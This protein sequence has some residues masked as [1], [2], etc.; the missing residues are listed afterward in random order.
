MVCGWE[1][2]TAAHS[3]NLDQELKQMKSMNAFDVPAES[4][5]KSH[6]KWSQVKIHEARKQF[7]Q[8]ASL[9]SKSLAKAP[10]KE[11]LALTSLSCALQDTKTTKPSQ[12]KAM[13]KNFSSL[14]MSL[15]PWKN[16]WGEV[17]SQ[18]HLQLLEG[19]IQEKSHWLKS[20]AS[21]WELL[22]KENLA[23]WYEEAGHIALQK[24][25]LEEAAYY[26]KQ[27]ND[28]V[29]QRVLQER[30]QN[31]VKK[32]A[33][34]RVAN[35]IVTALSVQEVAKEEE[36][37]KAL[38]ESKILRAQG[39]MVEYLNEFPQGRS[40]KKH[41]DGALDIYF[42]QSGSA[43][44]E[45][46]RQLAKADHSRIV[47]W[48]STL[49]RKSDYKG[50]LFLA[51]KIQGSLDASPQ[52]TTPLWIGGRSAHF[53]G[54]YE[55]AE[56][57]YQELIHKHLGTDQGIEALF[58]LGLIQ[59]RRE[60]LEDAA[61]LFERAR[62]LNQDRYGL[63]AAYWQV[64]AFE[65]LKDPRAAM[66]R[67]RLIERYPVS[68]YGLRLQAE[69]QEGNLD[70]TEKKFPVVANEKSFLYL[71]DSQWE[72]W[73]RFKALSEAGW[74]LE[75]QQELSLIP[76]PAT[77]QGLRKWVQILSRS[78]Q[79]QASIVV[80]NQLSDQDD[81]FRAAAVMDSVFPK[82]YSQ[83]ITEESARYNYDPDL[84][85]GLIRQESAFSLRALST[86]S[87][88]GLMQMI[89]PT[90]DEIARKLKMKVQIPQDMYRPDINIPMGSFY[91]SDM[92]QQFS[93]NVPMALGAYNAGPHR[94]KA[95]LEL[96]PE[97]FA[98]RERHSGE[99]Q[100]EI[101]FDELP[102]SETSF[103]I[104]A[105][106]RNVIMYRLI[107]KGRVNLKPVFWSD[108][109]FKKTDMDPSTIVK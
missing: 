103:Y 77:T 31:L 13:I 39:L 47:E 49:H 36:I 92:L 2:A 5:L 72:A 6:S 11:W 109:V 51:D 64:R 79:H 57:F 26:Y 3:V 7:A 38:Q 41:K 96:R 70:W 35:E 44:E 20:W 108:L 42:S 82:T 65:K 98:L 27:S 58:R 28:L 59:F 24:K 12:L 76:L 30:L 99:P 29:S 89:P 100:D 43:K 50:S 91:V 10:F 62:V 53:L 55:R 14:K 34:S 101:W 68:Y 1:L 17:W 9:G 8:C 56:K 84:L 81:S 88:M 18:A 105:I 23:R 66:E 4:P 32:S 54:D 69:K 90:A 106:L 94:L 104:K 107:D 19:P 37:S 95:W 15:G 61:I 33:P 85:R 75:A 97:V 73:K 67:D 83:W 80:L 60:K 86:S 40:V 93:Q 46:L 63:N 45:A 87:A 22:S 52:A 102:W 78:Y 25:N 71:Q 21:Q 48:L 16:A 74:I